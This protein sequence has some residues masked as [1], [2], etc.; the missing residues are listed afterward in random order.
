MLL[1]TNQSQEAKTAHKK[2]YG[3]T[4]LEV[5]SSWIIQ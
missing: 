5:E 2:K 1:D 3:L 4:K